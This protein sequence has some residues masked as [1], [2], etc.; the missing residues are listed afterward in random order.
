MRWYKVSG[1]YDDGFNR[2]KKFILC[3]QK[4]NLMQHS[5]FTT[6]QIAFFL[7]ALKRLMRIR[8]TLSILS[9]SNLTRKEIAGKR[10][11]PGFIIYLA[12]I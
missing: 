6:L 1:E 3:L 9:E 8:F 2:Y 7:V 5:I 12:R 10:K 4:A 11:Q